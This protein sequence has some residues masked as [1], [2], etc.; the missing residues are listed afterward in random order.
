MS[1]EERDD[2]QQG[3]NDMNDRRAGLRGESIQTVEA[4]KLLGAKG[5]LHIEHEGELY[6]LRLTK[7]NRLILTK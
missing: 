7:N 6:T 3:E 2:A 1:E 5:L 4:Q